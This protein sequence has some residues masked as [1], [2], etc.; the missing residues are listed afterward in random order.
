MAGP[1]T[2]TRSKGGRKTIPDDSESRD[3]SSPT[4]GGRGNV[5]PPDKWK[6]CF[7]KQKQLK[8][9]LLFFQTKIDIDNVK[10]LSVSEIDYFIAKIESMELRN[11]N[12]YEEM[13]LLSTDQNDESENI[14]FQTME[15]IIDLI[16][17]LKK[18]KAILDNSTKQNP[19]AIPQKSSDM[20]LPQLNIP[21]FDGDIQEWKSFQSMFVSAVKDNVS[22]SG[23][24]KLQFLKS[25]LGPKALKHINYLDICDQ[26]FDE[27]WKILEDRYDN[28]KDLI[29][30]HLKVLFEQD[31][32]TS[33]NATNLRSLI[34]TTKECLHSLKVLGAPTEHW[35]YIVVYIILGKLDF[36]S[37]RN[38][39]LSLASNE[40]PTLNKLIDFFNI[41]TKD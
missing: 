2:S 18:Q 32:L 33:E 14:Y 1:R 36:G 29:M 3:A 39:E 11:S 8:T 7:L 21:K 28:K 15:I 26:H 27:A 13:L 16:S 35:D 37:R 22:Y 19:I 10:R 30:S 34:D 6:S 24:R 5:P 25:I 12:N 20:I 31:Q 17:S 40:L 38:W 4:G 23:S 41:R 9:E